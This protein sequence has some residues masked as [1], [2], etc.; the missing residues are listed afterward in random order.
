MAVHIPLAP[1]AQSEASV[2]MKSSM[3]I[4]S[5]ANGA[6]ITVP[7]QDIVLGCYYLTK[8]KS[9]G[10]G[11]GRVFG[12]TDDVELALAAGEVETLSPIRLRVS[13]EFMDLTA[14]RDDQDV[15]RTEVQQIEKKVI[16][17]TVGRA[18]FNSS[19]PEGLPYVNGLLKKK[20]LGQL[21][22][23]CYLRHGVTKTVEMLDGLK[24]LGFGYATRSGLSIGID[25]RIVPAQKASLGKGA[26]D[27]VLRVEQQY[28]EALQQ[29]HCDLVGRDRE[30]CRR[31]VR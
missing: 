31:D 12:T 2:L 10:K 4:L 9:H 14:S 29:S 22:Q 1:E 21:V 28:L 3:N 19:L 17:T 26:G 27:E 13:G 5:P 30:G 7:S 25:D 15:L 24:N 6:P 20:G 11:E 8:A 23:Y 18:L 16:N